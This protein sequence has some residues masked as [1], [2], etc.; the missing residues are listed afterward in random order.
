ML[1]NHYLASKY[2]LR[3]TGGMVPD[4]YYILITGG[5]VFCNPSSPAHKQKLRLLYECAP[6]AMV[7]EQTPA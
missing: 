3:Y 4:I 6:I 2:T 7:C 5:G 1:L